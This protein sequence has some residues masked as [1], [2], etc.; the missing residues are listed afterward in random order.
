MSSHSIGFFS[1]FRSKSRDARCAAVGGTQ[2]DVPDLPTAAAQP[3]AL[4]SNVSTPFLSKDLH[5]AD[6]KSRSSPLQEAIRKVFPNKAETWFPSVTKNSTLEFKSKNDATLSLHDD[7]HT[8]DS[9]NDKLTLKIAMSPD[10]HGFVELFIDFTIFHA[11]THDNDMGELV[12]ETSTARLDTFAGTESEARVVEYQVTASSPIHDTIYAIALS[13][14]H[15]VEWKIESIVIKRNRDG[16]NSEGFYFPIYSWIVSGPRRLFFCGI[17][18]PHD[19]RLPAKIRQL[20]EEDLEYWRSKYIPRVVSEGLPVGLADKVTLLPHDEKFTSVQDF[21]KLSLLRQVPSISKSWR[22]DDVF[23]A[24]ILSGVNPVQICALPRSATFPLLCLPDTTIQELAKVSYLVGKDIAIEI[25]RGHFSYV[26]FDQLLGPFVER[27]NGGGDT[28]GADGST[29]KPDG[30]IAAPA[31]LFWHDVEGGKILPIAIRVVKN[32]DTFYPPA[33]GEIRDSVIN[34]WT[35]AKMWFGL[36]DANTHQL[37]THLLRTHL[38]METF[39]LA[40]TRHLSPHHPI[41]KILKPH[42]MGTMKINAAARETLIATVSAIFSL[43]EA[44]LDFVRHAYKSWNFIDSSPLRDLE[45][46]GFTGNQ[47]S[48]SSLDSPGQYPWAEDSRDLYS[49]IEKYVDEYICV[50]YDSDAAVASDYEL[51]S[52]IKEADEFNGKDKGVPKSIYTRAALQEVICILIWTST[53]QHSSVN[54]P[55]FD[56]AGYVPNRPTKSHRPPLQSREQV[57]DEKYLVESL[58]TVSEAVK[59][60]GIVELLSTY[61]ANQ[62]FLG[63]HIQNLS[64]PLRKKEEAVYANFSTNLKEYESRVNE[65]NLLKARK[66]NPY[67]WLS[68]SKVANSIDI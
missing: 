63:Q 27:I 51:Q 35:L 7:S 34:Q 19:T 12:V 57:I 41:F 42:F 13:S 64:V 2:K 47:E 29:K 55:Q 39:D 58:P 16:E 44:S 61:P 52:W 24:Q 10:N 67:I 15:T 49:V 37:S 68:P 28:A 9:E 26:D 65:R 22:N 60:I 54:F 66:E 8:S 30:F 50:Y 23:A 6:G 3:S 33:T 40:M 59:V 46:R 25:K 36:A 48:G 20:R 62:K 1:H 4:A 56:Y 38:V 14:S 18:T 31:A 17:S 11:Q 53:A 43:G 21:D 32:G 45:K 5:D